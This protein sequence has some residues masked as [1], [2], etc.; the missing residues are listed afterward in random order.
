MQTSKG[1]SEGEIPLPLPLLLPLARH[2][3]E[4]IAMEKTRRK[5]RRRR[6]LV[7]MEERKE[8]SCGDLNIKLVEMKIK[9]K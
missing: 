9:W 4:G 8:V 3:A 2:E 7:Q 5:R 6:S 1:I